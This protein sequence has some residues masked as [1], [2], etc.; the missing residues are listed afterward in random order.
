MAGKG[1]TIDG[2]TSPFAAPRST[3][4]AS[5]PRLDALLLDGETRQTLTCTRALG[6]SGLRVGVVAAERDGAPA[7]HS[8]WCKKSVLLPPLTTSSTAYID[9]LLRFL[10]EN[11][12]SVVVPAY[13]GSIEAVRERRQEIE[14]RTAVALAA[15]SALEVAVDKKKT[16]A[17]AR[18]LGIR[19]PR[20]VQVTSDADLEQA[21]SEV[22][23]PAVL[24]PL[25]S[26]STSALGG[27]R[28]GSLPVIT[29]DEAHVAFELIASQGGEATLQ[30]WLA[31]RRDA[32]T[33]FIDGCEVRACFAQTSHRELPRLGGVSVLCESIPPLADITGPA[34]RLVSSMGVEGC[35]MVEFRRDSNGRPGPHG[36]EPTALRIGGARGCLWH[37]LSSPHL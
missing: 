24:K 18:D 1:P 15:E 34:Q 27:V 19:T 13:D 5:P 36:G 37:R 35:S 33:L 4:S 17:V 11:P 31:G 26:W 25:R 14:K 22:G 28:L 29:L 12:T 20:A 10:D 9:G 3:F 2:Q 32:V 16:L 21:V 30:E 7:M 23:L 8:R 6:R